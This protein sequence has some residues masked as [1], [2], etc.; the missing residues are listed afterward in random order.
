MEESP[1]T[2]ADVDSARTVALRN[3]SVI[4]QARSTYIIAQCEDGVLVIDQHV[5]HERVL[6]EGMLRSREEQGTAVQ[7]LV[8]PLTLSLSA[9]EAALVTG[10]IDD[11]RKSGFDIESFGTNT[12]VVR[13]APAALKPG[14]AE[15]TLREMIQELVDLSVARHLVVRPDQVLIT[16]SCKMAVKAGE[17]LTMPEMTRLVED[18]MKCENPFVCP[19]GRP[20]VISLSN[21]ELDH[22]FHRG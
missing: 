19:H 12:F 11:I 10:R 22:K 4:G 13:G 9:R 17:P 20:I 1:V 15:A 3:V 6:F 8:I 5:A 16:A 18:L 7:G 14:V 2:E 21:W